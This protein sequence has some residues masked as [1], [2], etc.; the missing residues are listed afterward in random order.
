MNILIIKLGAIGDVVRTTCILSGLHEKYPGC[1]ITWVTK[2]GHAGVLSGISFIERIVAIDEAQS[3]I[4]MSRQE[5]FGLSICLDD[6]DEALSLAS[7]V[8]AKRKFGSFLH[9]CRKSYSED[10]QAWFDMSLLSRFGKDKADSLK[11]ANQKTYPQLLAEMLQIQKGEPVIALFRK[12]QSFAGAFAKRHGIRSGDGVIGINTGSGGRWKGKRLS[13]EQTANL[14]DAI[15]AKGKK[16]ILFGGPEEK[17]R[18][19]EIIDLCAKKPINAGTNNSLREFASLI[20]LC[21]CVICSDSLA[22]HLA[23]ALK[24]YA[25]TLIGPTSA[26]EI[27]LYGR[28]AKISPNCDC[29]YK[30]ECIHPKS[31]LERLELSTIIREIE[32]EKSSA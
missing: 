15:A 31:C 11:K 5:P 27:D 24:K 9:N 20:S 10:A 26:A 13:R 14:I 30:K 1:R 23:I 16:A 19:A 18:N 2:Q 6:E 29:F 4:Q 28:G 21:T 8:S 17:E 22:L 7:E 3:I 12:E 32:H 25:I